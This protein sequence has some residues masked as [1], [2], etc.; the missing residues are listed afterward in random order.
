MSNI[1]PPITSTAPV[2][3]NRAVRSF[4]LQSFPAQ[5]TKVQYY[6]RGVLLGAVGAGARKPRGRKCLSFWARRCG[7]WARAAYVF[8]RALRI[9]MCW[10]RGG[11]IQLGKCHAL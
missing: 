11:S 9:S 2:E 8:G 10:Q 6:D 7:L 3:Q 4:E 1:S 5:T